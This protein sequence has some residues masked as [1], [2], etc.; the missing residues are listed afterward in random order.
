[1]KK[2]DQK[3]AEQM[4]Y[5]RLG[6]IFINEE[7]KAGKFK[8]PM[9]L[10]MGHEAIAVA[11]SDALASEDKLVLSHR[12][13]AY[14][15]VRAGKVRPILDEYL[16]KSTGLAK[17]KLG[18]MNLIN[19]ERN[20]IYTSSILGNNFSVSSGIAMAEKV[21]G[22]SGVTFVLGGDGSMEEGS[23]Y[24]S[25]T[26]M[27]T[28]GLRIVVIIENNEWSLATKISERRCPIDLRKLTSA[29]DIS[30]ESLFG[31]DVEKYI[32]KISEARERALKNGPIC[33]EVALTTLGDS[34][35]PQTPE[36]PEG[37]YINYHAGP[38]S[39]VDIAR[40]ALRAVL[41]ESD[42]DPIFVLRE[43]MGKAKLSELAERIF[44]QIQRELV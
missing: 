31:N 35:G 15:L 30:Y 12:N 21:R 33:I 13:L 32:K 39:S 11:V 19:P 36:Y 42:E 22:L 16:L 41:K 3:A 17:A 27:K 44:K 9:H 23:F 37:K 40:H 29:L 26:M 10:A 24:E 25:L 38:S 2:F 6:Q 43:K 5:L 8:I 28:L 34:R 14:N 7:S 18:S 20:V 1:M 4:L